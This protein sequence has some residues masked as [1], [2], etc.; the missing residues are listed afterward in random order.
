MIVVGAGLAGLTA[1]RVLKQYK[2]LVLEA[3]NR[4]GGR[5]HTYLETAQ[6]VDLGCS[7]IH[8]YAEGNPLA[9]TLQELNL[10]VSSQT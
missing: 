4:I 3:R 6:P 8:G 2:P 10:P 9:Q 5:A 7:M 1:A